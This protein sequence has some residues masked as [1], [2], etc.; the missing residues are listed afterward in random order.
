MNINRVVTQNEPINEIIVYEDNEFNLLLE[1]FD[2][3]GAEFAD[4]VFIRVIMSLRTGSYERWTSGIVTVSSGVATIEF[5]SDST[6][7]AGDYTCNIEVV[8][9]ATTVTTNLTVGT[10]RFLVEEAL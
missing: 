9:D 8:D 3:L 2:D 6:S 1:L 10:F 4:G 5:D 7:E